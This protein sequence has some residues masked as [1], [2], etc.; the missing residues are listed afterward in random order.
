MLRWKSQEN[1]P[2]VKQI[3][4]LCLKGQLRVQRRKLQVERTACAKPQRPEKA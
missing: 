2:V 4:E 1:F 3:C